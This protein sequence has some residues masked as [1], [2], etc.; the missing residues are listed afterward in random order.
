MVYLIKADGS[1][2]EFDRNKAIQ[3]CMSA[4]APRSLAEKIVSRV[5]EH[6]RDG[7]TTREMKELIRKELEKTRHH[8]SRIYNLREALAV[9]DPS[10]HQ[11]EKFVASLF[12]HYGYVTVWEPRPKPRGSCTDHE[13]DVMIKKDGVLEFIECKHHYNPH[14]FTGLKVVMRVWARLEDLR[15][16]YEDGTP[17]SL[18]FEACW[19]VTNGKFSEHAKEYAE[20]RGVNLLGWNYPPWRGINHWILD[21]ECYPLSIL[22][23][24]PPA[25][26][27]LYN[28]GVFDT[29]LLLS[30]SRS[31]LAS[32]GL[33]SSVLKRALEIARELVTKP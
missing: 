23:L 16:G 33:P 28:V 26:E 14:K 19:V 13:I 1:R 24:D 29:V 18:P 3:S 4:G 6:L 12:A 2:Q 17:G 30:A 9:L 5:E 10:L 25:I 22:G 27:K 21:K 8:S 32:T 15:R 20:C 31:Q 7:M 11:F